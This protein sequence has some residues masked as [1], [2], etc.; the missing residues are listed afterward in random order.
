MRNHLWT[1]GVLTVIAGTESTGGT[2]R[3]GKILQITRLNYGVDL[4][5]SDSAE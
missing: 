4:N 3:P 1:I 2:L 5:R